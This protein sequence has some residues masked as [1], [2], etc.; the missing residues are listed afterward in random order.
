MRFSRPI[1]T[2]RLRRPMSASISTTL[3][4]SCA[5]AVPRLQVV[6]VFPTPP[7]PDVMTIARPMSVLLHARGK[8]AGK[9]SKE[10]LDHDG[11]AGGIRDLRA[12]AGAVRVAGAGDH[13]PDPELLRLQR[14]RDDA[15]GITADRRV[16][17]AAQPPQHDDAALGADL[18]AGVDIA[19]HDQVT[20]VIDDPSRSDRA[21]HQP[22][23][24]RLLVD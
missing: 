2:S 8:A 22:G 7:L 18:G 14:Q 13:A 3:M 12:A 20:C 19:D 23:P 9:S 1:T 17:H 5:M 11:L 4:P 21:D 10:P 6:V 24:G 15:A 16:R